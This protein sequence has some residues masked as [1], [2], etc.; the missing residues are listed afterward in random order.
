MSDSSSSLL[1]LLTSTRVRK[2][3]GCRK[4]K[5]PLISDQPEPWSARTEREQI[6]GATLCRAN[7]AL[8]GP[9]SGDRH[10]PLDRCPLL[11]CCDGMQLGRDVLIAPSGRLRSVSLGCRGCLELLLPL[12][13]SPWGDLWML[14]FAAAVGA[15]DVRPVCAGVPGRGALVFAVLPE[16]RCL[17]AEFNK[18]LSLQLARELRRRGSK[19]RRV[20]GS[21]C[22]PPVFADRLPGA[23]T[24]SDWGF[25]VP[26]VRSFL[27]CR[28]PLLCPAFPGLFNQSSHSCSKF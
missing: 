20:S 15:L 17:G 10:R 24:G 7:L 21:H 2:P 12:P 6:S 25:P 11:S 5:I 22:F 18:T 8:L 1:G 16:N 9:R 19:S 28:A 13:N 14:I 3:P 23:G 26:I 4:R 27:C